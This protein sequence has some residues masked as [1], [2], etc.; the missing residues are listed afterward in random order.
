MTT[1]APP[2]AGQRRIYYAED[3]KNGSM[4]VSIDFGPERFDEDIITMI[5]VN[6]I[7]PLR[8]YDPDKKVWTFKPGAQGWDAAR[9][10]FES[11]GYYVPP[12]PA[13]RRPPPPP[14]GPQGRRRRRGAPSPTDDLYVTLCLTPDAPDALVDA[15][16]RV[17]ARVHHSDMQGGS[18]EKMKE[19]TNAYN[20]IKESR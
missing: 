10:T 3:V 2:T 12:T 5:K 7:S 11:M 4:T 17:F 13:N 6:V 18:D 8:S 9:Q 16:L 1:S 19:Y 15:A 14:G 20:A